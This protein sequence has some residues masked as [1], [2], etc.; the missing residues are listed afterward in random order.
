[1]RHKKQKEF[2]FEEIPRIGYLHPYKGGS[3][4]RVLELISHR[5]KFDGD[6]EIRIILWRDWNTREVFTSGTKTDML[7]DC[8][9]EME[10]W[11]TYKSD[12]YPKGKKSDGG[13]R[14]VEFEGLAACEAMLQHLARGSFMGKRCESVSVSRGETG[15][16]VGRLRLIGG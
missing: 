6:K 2:D 1:M 11:L 14:F 5:S 15:E 4:G 10:D 9:R 3:D 12:T 8:S 16:I 7:M 13:T